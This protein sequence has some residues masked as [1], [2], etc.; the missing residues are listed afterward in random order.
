M[1]GVWQYIKLILR[2]DRV[3]LPVWIAIILLFT[4]SLPLAMR[5]TTGSATELA[6]LQSQFSSGNAVL[7]LITGPLET[8]NGQLGLGGITMVKALVF[9]MILI[10][11]F[12][13]LFVIRHTRQNEEIGAQELILSEKVSRFAP[14]TATLMV[15]F[16][17]IALT[18]ILSALGIFATINGTSGGWGGG[19]PSV[20]EGAWLFSLAIGGVGFAFAGIAAVVAQLTETSSTANGILGGIIGVAFLL[21]GVGDVFITDVAGVPTAAAWSW[22]SPFGWA[23]MTHSLTFARWWPLMIFAI[24]TF[25]AVAIA[26]V[27]LS[28]R[29]LG[30]GL[31]PARKGRARANK[32]LKSPFGLTWKLQRAMFLGWLFGT[33]AMSVV[34]G[35]MAQQINHIYSASVA[36]REMVG[37]LGGANN[38]G[39]LILKTTLL[40]LLTYM[41]FMAV[42]FTIQSLGKLRA[43]ESSGHLENLLATRISRWSWALKHIFAAFA[44]SAMILVPAGLSI[45]VAANI[46]GVHPALDIWEFTRAALTHLPLVLAAIGIYVFFYGVAPR[47]AGAITWACYTVTIAVA[48][49]GSLFAALF[50]WL[51]WVDQLSPVL[52]FSRIAASDATSGD[53][54]AFWLTI[55][56]ALILFAIGLFFWR[57]RNLASDN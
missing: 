42:A 21:R 50:H 41:V 5:A 18:T 29:D 39:S 22:F 7:N 26:Y 57:R 55:V 28:R 32:L 38:S 37:S 2:R 47:F 27:L 56:G 17:A 34:I 48:M 33:V 45:A 9:M 11:F 8:I 20:W 53:W 54:L 51:D 49:F 14:L 43:E 46:S 40:G 52:L 23:Q 24:F 30:A 4:I 35:A 13:T 3:K 44:G 19:A 36:M 25:A 31:L 1:A 12:A 15:A 6:T 16:S 10:A